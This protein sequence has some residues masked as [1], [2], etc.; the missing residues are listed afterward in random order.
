MHEP[1]FKQGLGIG[2][3][4]SPKGADHT[5]SIHD[6][7][8]T[9]ESPGLEDFKALGILE[10][11]ALEDLGPAKV[12]MTV[13]NSYWQHLLDCLLLCN[14]MPFNYHQ[15]EELVDAVTGWN[16]T[17]WEL[18]KVGERCQNLTRV[19]N[20]REGLRKEDDHLPKRFFTPISSGPIKGTRINRNNFLQARETYYSM[21]GW[22]KT[23][24]VPTLGK[25]QELDIGWVSDY[26]GGRI[27]D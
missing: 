11:L 17:M 19:F 15:V 16:S 24:G 26:L 4:V 7:V 2:Y 13:Y 18:M 1:R 10:P 23:S 25:L 9:S 21:M 27:G 12:R 14:Y 3:G 5:F 20:I 6:N 8:Y 22:E